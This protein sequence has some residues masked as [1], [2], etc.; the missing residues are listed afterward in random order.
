MFGLRVPSLREGSRADV[1]VI[2]PERAWTVD[3]KRLHSKSRNTPFE[4][5]S[6]KGRVERTFV[7][8]REVYLYP[9]EG[10]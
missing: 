1:V 9:G 8:G 2:D 3:P 7:A 5:W 10:V 4:G 6:V